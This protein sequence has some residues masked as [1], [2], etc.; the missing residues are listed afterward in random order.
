MQVIMC[1]SYAVCKVAEQEVVGKQEVSFRSII[2][3]YRQLTGE[4]EEV[5]FHEYI[6]CIM[7]K[8]DSIKT[9]LCCKDLVTLRHLNC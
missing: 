5:N 8:G 4:S 2:R 3:A 7:V 1:A 9:L 6:N